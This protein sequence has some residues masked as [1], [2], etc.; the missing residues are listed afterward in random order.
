MYFITY[1]AQ[2]EIVTDES[3]GAYINCY[4]QKKSYFEADRI[5]RT[6]IKELNWIILSQ[7]DAF[8][9]DVETLSDDGKK[10][11]AQALIDQTV[12]VFH[13]YPE[14]DKHVKEIDIAVFTT[15]YVLEDKRIIT[16]VSHEI[17]DGAWQF[18][19]DDKF[20]D[21][22]KVVRVVGFNE[23]MDLDPTLRE[24]VDMEMG[25]IATRN[26]IDDKWTIKQEN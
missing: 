15:K 8:E 20:E 9:I 25:Y 6:E 26:N 14:T 13:T 12:Y 16:Y 11:Y 5:A 21:F 3:A 19:S 1:H 2:A 23:M 10:Y 18:F 22:S 7:E 24:L 4:I 17:E